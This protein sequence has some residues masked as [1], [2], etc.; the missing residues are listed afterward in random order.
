M[1]G[2]DRINTDYEWDENNA[3]THDG[4]CTHIL[5]L[6]WAC[7]QSLSLPPLLLPL[8]IEYTCCPFFPFLIPC[9][10][11]S[12]S[13]NISSSIAATLPPYVHRPA[14]GTQSPLQPHP[15]SSSTSNLSSTTATTATIHAGT[16]ANSLSPGYLNCRRQLPATPDRRCSSPR[17]LPTPPPLSPDARCP[18]SAALLERRA[19]GRVLPRAPTASDG[20]APVSPDVF[21][22]GSHTPD[23]LLFPQSKNTAV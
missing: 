12:L 18:S 11:I 14:Y 8:S 5:S 2:W 22:T 1:D 17:I 16:S 4:A 19:S 3:D 21:S 6:I 23:R 20:S 10:L 7:L 9:L 13:L 15:P